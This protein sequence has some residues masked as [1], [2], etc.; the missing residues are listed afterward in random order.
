[1]ELRTLLPLFL[2]LPLATCV[3]RSAPPRS[4]G[5]TSLAAGTFTTFLVETDCVDDD[6]PETCDPPAGYPLDLAAGVA[7]VGTFTPSDAMCG[8]FEMTVKLDRDEVW[9]GT[10][11]GGGNANALGT[12]ILG[13]APPGPHV[14]SVTA[15]ADDACYRGRMKVFY[16]SFTIAATDPPRGSVTSA[17]ALPEVGDDHTGRDLFVTCEPCHGPRGAGKQALNAPAIAGQ[18]PWYLARQIRNFQSGRRGTHDRDLYG[19]QMRPMALEL[20]NEQRIEAIVD[21]VS[22]LPAPTHTST[23]EGDVA[24]GAELFLVCAVCHGDDGAGNQEV[25]AP[26]LTVQQDWYLQRQI[27]NFRDGLRGY[28]ADDRYG[29]EMRPMTGTLPD[30]QAIRDVI[31]FIQQLRSEGGR[32]A[33]EAIVA[34]GKPAPAAPAPAPAPEPVAAAP[35]PAPTA[36]AP[37]PAPKPKP[38]PVAAPAP[39]PAPTGPSKAEL[40]AKGKGVYARVCQPCHQA[41]GQGIPGAFPPLAGAGGFY[42]SPAK[43]A[44]IIVNG[45]SGSIT[46]KGQ[47]F[48]SAMPP[49]G[50]LSDDDIAAVAT[51][52][53]N[54]W[55]NSDGIVTP[56]QVRAAR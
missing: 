56:A 10:V 4:I 16:G 20:D 15:R 13:Q 34:S 21:Y 27:L 33:S 50:S 51:Y 35:A 32:S 6:S 38:A 31:A 22:K 39:K 9:K 18:E 7:L 55:G 5:T 53:R 52:V 30:G 14:L 17:G 11:A 49:Q 47:T 28:H 24:R 8:P 36:P 19:M 48:N 46:V 29:Q 41:N 44:G 45:L 2:A 54:S 3:P 37:A 43:M 26:R 25:G 12:F 23:I 42:G 40:M 1:M